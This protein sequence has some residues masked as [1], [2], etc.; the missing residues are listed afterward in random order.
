MIVP[1]SIE[2]D[3]FPRVLVYLGEDIPQVLFGLLPG[4]FDA[5]LVD[6]DHFGVQNPLILVS[7]ASQTDTETPSPNYKNNGEH[8]DELHPRVFGIVHS[9]F[10]YDTFTDKILVLISQLLLLHK[11]ICI[12]KRN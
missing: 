11:L 10:G 2:L 8:L 12:N 3:D 9:L 1:E 7:A 6:I 4:Y 5:S